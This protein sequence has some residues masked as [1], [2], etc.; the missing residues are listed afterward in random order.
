[1]ERG[2]ACEADQS[3]FGAARNLKPDLRDLGVTHLSLFV[4][5]LAW[6]LSVVRR[7]FL[8]VHNTRSER[9]HE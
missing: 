3:R 1:M 2:R 6:A 5:R 9:L 4:L 8:V 7:R